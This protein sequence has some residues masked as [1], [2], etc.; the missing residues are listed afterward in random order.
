MSLEDFLYS[1]YKRLFTKEVFYRAEFLKSYALN[2]STCLR[3]RVGLG[4]C[5]PER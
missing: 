3:H 2:V 4:P 5:H 1:K